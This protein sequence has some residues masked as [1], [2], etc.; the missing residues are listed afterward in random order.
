M[1]KR[2][3]AKRRR[4]T[5][6]RQANAG[7]SIAEAPA[8]PARQRPQPQQRPVRAAA[9]GAESRLRTFAIGGSALVGLIAFVVY[10]ATLDPSVGTGDSG[11][12]VASAY[13]WGVAHPP[14]YPLYTMLGHLATWLPFGSPALR[15]NLLSAIFD[16]ATVG[17]VCLLV[18]R[19]VGDDREETSERTTAR[20]LAAAVGA[21]LLAF[22]TVFW[23]YSEVAEVF[24]LNNLF[25]ALLLLVAF[26]WARRPDRVRV[27]WLFAFL[28]GL[29]LTNQQT[30]VLLVPAFLVLAW[31]VWR[32][33]RRGT[34]RAPRV[35][36]PVR[37]RDVG[38]ACGF[39][40]VGLLPYAYLP[41]AARADP[42]M[43]WGDPRT[44]H[45]FLS[46]VTR[47]DYGTTRLVAGRKGSIG[48][49]LDLLT[50]NLSRGFVVVGIVL[51]VLGLWWTARNRRAVAVA[52]A[53]AFLFAGPIFV[54][55]ARAYIPD[56]LTKGVIERFYILPS[57]PLAVLAGVG[58]WQ[59]I[60]WAERL[61]WPGSRS[62]L[63]LP[64]VGVALLAAP[65]ASAV[66]H[67]ARA[68]QSGNRVALHYAEDVLGP[69]DRN[70]LLIMRSDENYTSV[71]YAQF[72]AGFRRDVVAMDAERL[73]Q[74]SFVDQMRRQHPA[75]V[76][77]FEFYD[78]GRTT[79]LAQLVQANLAQR[80]V[81]YVGI[82]EEKNFASGFDDVHA[83]FAHQLRPKGK[84]PDPYSLLRSRAVRFASLHYPKRSYPSTSWEEVIAQSYGGVAFDVGYALQTGGGNVQLAE[85]MFRTAISLKPDLPA[86]YKNLGLLLN[87]NGGDPKEIIALWQRFLRLAPNDR[88][89]GAIRASIARLKARG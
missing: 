1:S 61:R 76:I 66:V 38:V 2:K 8:Q 79:E 59:V 88:D 44:F 32:G 83:G 75:I 51:A 40:A 53:V 10:V 30:I 57:I 18:Y 49:Q 47:S 27:L 80:P 5:P 77:P 78:G 35:P 20:L 73:K 31:S 7:S 85:K 72:V 74:S 69:L 84:A 4:P 89:A 67:H 81:Y 50:S 13:V 9:A 55:Y 33:R 22:S 46:D 86:A 28:F 68:D 25:A 63:V 36:G 62:Q 37:L 82:M 71:S 29:A 39:F 15:M 60:L 52:L 34:R 21:L 14:G 3:R 70:A 65:V 87:E 48:E 19:L 41:L 43:N 42:P 64:A 17:I 16:A 6:P 11:E 45:S 54:A 24:A 56:D 58:A 12:L 23:L 26:E